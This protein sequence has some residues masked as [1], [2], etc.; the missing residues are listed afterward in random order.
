M[1]IT[2]LVFFSIF[3]L[4][5]SFKVS[6]KFNFFD[7]PDNEKIHKEI[8][9]NLGGLALI[10]FILLMFYFFDYSQNISTTL[11]LFL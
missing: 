9:P 5:L 7:I 8:I 10:P 2:Y 4:Y 3:F 1:Q 11:S 6:T